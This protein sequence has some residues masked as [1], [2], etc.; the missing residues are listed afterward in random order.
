MERSSGNLKSDLRQCEDSLK[1]LKGKLVNT[2]ETIGSEK[3]KE[4][5]GKLND[6]LEIKEKI[7]ESLKEE[8]AELNNEIVT[9]KFKTA[10]LIEVPWIL[11]VV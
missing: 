4:E 2:D 1:E 3:H 11:I 5:I 6:R 9:L 10:S 8:A 7:I